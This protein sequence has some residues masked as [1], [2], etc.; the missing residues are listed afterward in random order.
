MKLLVGRCAKLLRTTHNTS[1]PLLSYLPILGVVR[2]YRQAY[3]D[4]HTEPPVG[5]VEHNVRRPERILRREQDA[6][7][8]NAPLELGVGRPSHGEVPLEEVAL[9]GCGV[10][11]IRRV[12]HELPNICVYPLDGRVLDIR[13]HLLGYRFASVALVLPSNNAG[14][15]LP[16]AA[17]LVSGC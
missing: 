16:P 14:V 1:T 9:Q 12:F 10:I 8:V 17:L 15:S 7:V 5:R 6:A 13:R 11:L 4:P 2:R 3:L